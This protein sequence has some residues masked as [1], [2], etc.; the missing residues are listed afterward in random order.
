MYVYRTIAHVK[1]IAGV[2]EERKNSLGLS[3]E[4]PLHPPL[5]LQL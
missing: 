4:A 5:S 3:P 2:G 1:S